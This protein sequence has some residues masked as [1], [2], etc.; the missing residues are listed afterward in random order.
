MANDSIDR[1]LKADPSAR[2]RMIDE[3]D[4]AAAL[5]QYF[6]TAAFDEYAAVA[7]RVRR[8]SG[9]RVFVRRPANLVFVPGVMGSQLQ[10]RTLGGIWWLDLR[11]LDKLNRMKISADGTEDATASIDVIA[12]TSDP[13][14]EAFFAAILQ[15]DDFAHKIFPF[16]WRKSPAFSAAAL[17]DTIAALHASNGGNPVH[18]VAHSMGGLVVRAALTRYGAEIWPRLGRIVFIATP[19]YGS[20][21]MA[22]YLKNHLWGFE[23]LTLLGLYLSRETFRSLWG[24]LSMLPAPRGIYPGTRPP[25]VDDAKPRRSPDP[26][27]RYVHPCANFDLYDAQAWKLDLSA[28]ETSRLQTILDGTAALHKELYQAHAGFSQQQRDSMCM[29]AGVG[30]KTLFRLAYRDRLLGLWEHMDKVTDRIPGDP[31]REGDGR[32]TLASAE[33]EQIGAIRYFNGVHGGLPMMAPV[34][35]DVFRWLRNEPLQLPR[36]PAEALSQ[37]VAAR[38]SSLTPHLDGTIRAHGDD[39]GY[40]QRD[41]PSPDRVHALQRQLEKGTLPEFLSVRVF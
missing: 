20:P 29:I 37:P 22:G 25:G 15:R 41:A 23:L 21:S 17:R 16:D 7:A 39:P 5:R 3:P 28:E 10:S 26:G 30:Y 24:M 19:H 36:T 38:A 4:H 40:W 35:A 14:Y 13:S 11:G 6:G 1:F 2:L 12:A 31:H 32:V 34:Y 8:S 9:G 18:V 33:L 27:D